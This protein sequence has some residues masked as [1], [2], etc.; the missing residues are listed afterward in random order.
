MKDDVT[1]YGDIVKKIQCGPE[2]RVHSK[3]YRWEVNKMACILEKNDHSNDQRGIVLLSTIFMLAVIASMIAAFYKVS[4]VELATTFSNRQS[5]NGFYSA[6]SGLNIRASEIKDTFDGYN[7]PTGSSPSTSTPCEAGDD[8]SG[9]FICRNYSLN[10]QNVTTYMVEEPG[11]PIVT[12]IPSGEL[13]QNLNAHEY[14]YSVHSIAKDKSG[15]T[16]AQLELGFKSRLVPI[17][18]FLAFFNKDLEIYSYPLLSL[19]GPIH[20]NGDIYLVSNSGGMYINGQMTTTED[21]YLGYK[22][23][24]GTCHYVF[25]DIFFADPAVTNPVVPGDYLAYDRCSLMSGRIHPRPQTDFDP[26]NSMVQTHVPL[27]SVPPVDS[28]NPEPG[29]I[30][31]DKADLRLVLNLDSTDTATG[32]EVRTAANTVDTAKTTLLNTNCPSAASHTNDLYDAREDPTVS[33]KSKILEIDMQE[34]LNC[35]HNESFLGY[36]KALDDDTDG[37]LVLYLTLDGPNSASSQSFYGSRI[38]NAAELQASAAGAATVRGLTIVSDQ[39]IYTKGNYNSINKIPA[40]LMG[41]MYTALSSDWDD[42]DSNKPLEFRLAHTPT[43]VNAALISGFDTTCKR[44]HGW[45]EGEPCWPNSSPRDSSGGLGNIIRLLEAWSHH[46]HHFHSA[47]AY[48][49]PTNFVYRGS[50]VSLAN[51][52]HNDGRFVYGRDA[53]YLPTTIPGFVG[54]MLPPHN[55]WKYDQDF[56]NIDNLPPLTPRFVYLKQELFIKDYYQ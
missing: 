17:F 11:N 23:Q 52:Q 49:A 16:T 9:D 39:A 36:S 3:P 32:V 27:I 56:N 37:G 19:D 41:D 5:V 25:A 14:R 35:L 31:W 45:P 47:P 30:F 29:K 50:L 42:I 13:Y 2:L 48:F 34:L 46:S 55:D 53:V 15:K 28:F 24:P 21:I 8:G 12:T 43:T 33:R 1:N 44:D 7:L 22:G 40:A 6:E 10:N 20:A 26:Y 54:Q 51:S 18:Q 38:S 4:K